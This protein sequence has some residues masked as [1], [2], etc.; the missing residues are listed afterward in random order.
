MRTSLKEFIHL[1][2]IIKFGLQTFIGNIRYTYELLVL[3]CIS[4]AVKQ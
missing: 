2:N 3:K 1:K 4:K